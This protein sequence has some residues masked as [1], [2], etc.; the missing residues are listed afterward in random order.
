MRSIA[1]MALVAA[2]TPSIASAHVVRHSS[3]PQAYWGTWTTSD[4]GCGDAGKA[5]VVLSAKAYVSPAGNCTV[6]SV[7]ETPGEQ[8][9]TYSA[10]LQCAGAAGRTQKKSA[11]NLI[12]R[13]DRAGRISAGPDFDRLASYQ[14]CDAGGAGAKP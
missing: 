12:I 1:L 13:P 10:R 11:A 3:I 4:G 2:L 6:D 7:S 8:G 5:A 14:R 9:P